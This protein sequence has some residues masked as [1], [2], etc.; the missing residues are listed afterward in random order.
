MNKKTDNGFIPLDTIV[1]QKIEE[2]SNDCHS[3]LDG[4]WYGYFALSDE[5]GIP[6]NELKK[7]CKKL[8]TNGTIKLMPTYNEDGVICGSGY[9]TA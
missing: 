2:W 9:F 5:T 1:R 7:I 3:G 8:R 6:I 4:V